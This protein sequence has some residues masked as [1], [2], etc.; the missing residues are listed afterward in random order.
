MTE[1]RHATAAS[2]Y[3][4]QAYI[5]FVTVRILPGRTESIGTAR[6]TKSG[7]YGQYIVRKKDKSMIPF[8]VEVT[9][10]D[11]VAR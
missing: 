11:I 10:F 7:L 9:L 4:L 8:V 2:S 6:K 5:R 1:N 3:V